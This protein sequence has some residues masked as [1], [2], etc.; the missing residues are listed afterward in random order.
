MKLPKARHKRVTVSLT[1]TLHRMLVL[2][3]H[4]ATRE[5]GVLVSEGAIIRR[6]LVAYVARADEAREIAKT[7]G[8]RK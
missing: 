7:S 8:L 1:P 4:R 5:T 2:E 6:A 3:S